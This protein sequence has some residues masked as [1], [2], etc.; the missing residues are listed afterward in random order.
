MKVLEICGAKI[1]R[2]CIGNVSSPI[3]RE[4][5]QTKFDLMDGKEIEE[6]G[7]CLCIPL[8]PGSNHPNYKAYRVRR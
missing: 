6:M 5:L 7:G 8:S 4:A 2:D 1:S 3:L